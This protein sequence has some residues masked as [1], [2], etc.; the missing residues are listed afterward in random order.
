MLKSTPARKKYTTAGGVVWTNISYGQ[1]R[2]HIWKA[3]K[4]APVKV[5]LY[6]GYSEKHTI[7]AHKNV[8][9]RI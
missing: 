3:T 5:L 7:K 4:M 6:M 8:T 2:V 1:E 9:P